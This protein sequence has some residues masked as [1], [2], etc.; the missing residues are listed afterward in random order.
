MKKLCITISDW[1]IVEAEFNRIGLEVEPFN[2]IVEENRVLGF[3]KSVYACME[4]CKKVTVND[5]GYLHKNGTY[6][7][8]G[9]AVASV[10]I[11]YE[12]LLLF[13]DDVK[14]DG[15]INFNFPEDAFTVHLGCN[16]IGM[17][18]TVWEMPTRG[19]VNGSHHKSEWQMPTNSTPAGFARLHNCWQTHAIWYSKEAVEFILKNFKFVTDEYKTEG[20]QIFDEW[21]RVNVLPLKQSYVANPMVAY[22][23]PRWS[24]IWNCEADYTGCHIQGNKWLKDNL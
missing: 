11:E 24:E 4:L 8:S 17:D 19:V 14:F 13:E 18:T 10:K 7:I 6:Y 20:C 22:Q 2:A 12:D 15:E 23:R 5:G 1:P 3:N 21:L 16:I 9:D